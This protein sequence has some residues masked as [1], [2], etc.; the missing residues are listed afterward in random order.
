MKT[1]EPSWRVATSLKGIARAARTASAC[2]ALL[3]LSTQGARASVYAFTVLAGNAAVLDH[4]DGTG[5]NARFFNPTAVAVDSAGNIYVAD[6]G[7]HTVR[8]VTSSGTVTTLAGNSG[9]PGSID[10]TGSGALFLY[11]YALAVDSGG[12]VYVAD[13]GNNNI[14]KITPSGSVSTVAG[15]AGIAGSANGTGTAATFNMPEGIAVDASDNVYVSDTNN[16]TLRKITPAGVVTTLAGTAGSTGSSD[17]TGASARFA[18]PAGIGI[19]TSGN[20]YVADFGNSTIRMVTA[21]GV[22]TTVAGSA[23]ATGTANGSGSAARFN[24]PSSVTVDGAGNLYVIDTSNQLLREIVAGGTVSTLAGTA[25]IVGNANG[26]GAAASFFYPAGVAATSGGTV[27]VADTGNHLVRAVAPG[28]AVSTL[29]GSAGQQGSIDGTG[30]AARFSYPYGVA[31]DGSGHVYIADHGNDT[32]RMTTA[33]GVVTTIAG[34]PGVTGSANGTGAAARFSG[35][36]GLAADGNGNVYVADSG[37]STIRKIA[38]GAVVTTLA[39]QAGTTGTNDGAGTA[40]QFNSPA[41]IAVDSSGNVYVA[42]MN[43]DT[44]RKITS[45]G[46]VTTL[47][48]TAGQSGSTDGTG[49]GARFNGPDAVAVDNAGNVYVADQFNAT[50]RKVTPTGTVTTLAGAAGKAGYVDATGSVARFN[51]P[52]AISV[53]SGGNVYVADTYN[54]AIRVVTAGG[55][56]TTLNGAETRFYYPQGMAMDANGTIYVADGDNQSV[57]AGG[58]LSAP[59]S[60]ST[61]PDA[62][63]TA[64]QNATFTT[65]VTGSSMSYQWQ[66]SANSGSS[67]TD[68]SD[69]SSYSGS[70]SST[71]TVEDPT[72]AMNGYM[73]RVTLTNAAGSAESAAA[74]LAVSGSGGGGGPTGSA[75]ITNLSIRS[76]VGTGA[77]TVAVGFYISGSGSKQ[78]LIRGVGPT[79][80]EFG[81]TGLLETPDLTIYNSSS[82]AI[83]S[84]TAWGGSAALANTFASLGAFGLPANSADSAVDVTLAAG[85]TYTAQISGVNSTTGVA[86]AELYDA[87]GANATSRLINVS[88]RALCGSGSNVLIAGF[89][90]GGSGTDTLVIRGVGPGLSQFGVTGVLATPQLTVFDSSGNAVATNTGWGNSATLSAAFSQVGAFPLPAGSADSALLVTLPAG[91]YT[92]EVAGTNNSTGIALVEVYEVP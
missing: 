91:N 31:S 77:N 33:G 72:S 60:G 22:V 87:D 42:D 83:D 44:I 82:V 53:D 28:G 27:Y 25:G 18:Y 62:S 64:G 68:T 11:P 58:A 88:T 8:K 23:G 49:G 61:V 7:D 76:Y 78:L 45:A 89:V 80:S 26:T 40:A 75:R 46:V 36:A 38:P 90:I 35:P 3:A 50:I 14:R 34:D 66:V 2:A 65:S 32:I 39:G 47:A 13:T 54:R 12:N 63:V 59:P 73:Y 15:S 48:G 9:Q 92:A 19:D 52:Y 74:T 81:V 29:A 30:T 16:S 20:L 1:T 84:D 6:G 51:Q 70:T 5:T 24:H 43:N 37:N 79:L 21:S 56:V 41:G 17:G 71:L 57:S 86:L 10:G 4:T 85:T 69:G 55:S 67:W